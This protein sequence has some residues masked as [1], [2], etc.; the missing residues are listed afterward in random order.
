MDCPA[1]A[2]IADV[3]SQVET[4]VVAS[5]RQPA[6]A[7]GLAD[8]FTQTLTELQSLIAGRASEE[9]LVRGRIGSILQHL[10]RAHAAGQQVVDQNAKLRGLLFAISPRIAALRS[11]A[12]RCSAD[13]GNL[14]K[15]CRA[16]CWPLLGPCLP[17]RGCHAAFSRRECTAV[18]AAPRRPAERR[19]EAERSRAAAEV[20]RARRG[21]RSS[22]EGWCAALHKP[23]RAAGS[24][25]LPAAGLPGLLLFP[26]L[27]SRSACSRR[28]PACSRLAFSAAVPPTPRSACTMVAWHKGPTRRIN[29]IA[30]Y[31]HRMCRGDATMGRVHTAF[32]HPCLRHCVRHMGGINLKKAKRPEDAAAERSVLCTH[33]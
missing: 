29:R 26:S 21:A 12:E 33:T 13:H 19:A 3:L 5:S 17:L 18:A 11:N 31:A 2:Q 9:A 16:G 20:R 25:R 27:H 15:V 28:E 22:G 10:Q 7:V 23:T 30:S 32:C 14:L 6:N 8:G 4:Q 1:A 24:R